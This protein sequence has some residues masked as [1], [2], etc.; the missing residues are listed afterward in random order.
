MKLLLTLA[1]ASWSAIFNGAVA[2]DCESLVNTHISPVAVEDALAAVRG[3]R[4]LVR[5]EFETTS[6]FE[7]RVA[8]ANT[9]VPEIMH[10]SVPLDLNYVVYNADE[11]AFEVK[12]YGLKNGGLNYYLYLDSQTLGALG[13]KG[14]VIDFWLGGDR[15]VT[16]QSSPRMQT[17]EDTRRAIFER[18]AADGD[19]VFGGTGQTWNISVPI[20]QARGFRERMRAAL[21]VVPKAPY[22]V[23]HRQRSF[24]E[25]DRGRMIINVTQFMVADIQC[26]VITDDTNNILLAVPTR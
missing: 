18:P 23:E 15:R 16:G 6:Q 21:V 25:A 10:I 9:P 24:I 1:A 4:G 8:A 5:D 11:G 20:D 3:G 12:S 22:Y 26:A 13:V 14:S 2:Q 17:V 19:D 7:A